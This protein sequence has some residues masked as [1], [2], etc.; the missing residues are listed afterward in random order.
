MTTDDKLWNKNASGFVKKPGKG[1]LH[2][3]TSIQDGITYNVKVNFAL[4]CFNIAEFVA[5]LSFKIKVYRMHWY[6]RVNEEFKL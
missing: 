2:S 1:W 3:D 5:H 4:N 6:Q